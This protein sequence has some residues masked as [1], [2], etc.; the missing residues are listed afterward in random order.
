VVR[1]RS[2][3]PREE[4]EIDLAG[5]R[6]VAVNVARGW[7]G[8]SDEEGGER[9][10]SVEVADLAQWASWTAWRFA[11][12]VPPPGGFRSKGEPALLPQGVLIRRTRL[13]R[14]KK[15]TELTGRLRT[16]A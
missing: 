7:G 3:E 16:H 13:Q 14:K 6:R 4:T 15:T 9:G 10:W 2:Q 8:G 1:R 5:E 11:Q 12:P